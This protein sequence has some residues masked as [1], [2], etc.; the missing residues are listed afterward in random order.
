[1]NRRQFIMSGVALGS[2]L[3][4]APLGYSLYQ[5]MAD[6][7]DG[8]AHAA[9]DPAH[10]CPARLVLDALIPAFLHGALASD[11]RT[12]QIQIARV[13]DDILSFMP[14]LSLDTQHELQQLFGL[15]QHRLARL[16]L[17]GY[18]STLAELEMAQRIALINSW[19]D[20][21]VK[22]LQDAWQGL[23]ELCTGAFYGDPT[24]WPLLRYP[25]LALYG[26]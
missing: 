14:F 3:A 6:P 10:D 2:A 7:H 15:L 4:F 17:T 18:L 11:T 8:Q 16:A 19:R 5:S 9:L 22:L 1:M 12:A 24:Q 25:G 20:S 26:E 13:R 23:K 21:Y